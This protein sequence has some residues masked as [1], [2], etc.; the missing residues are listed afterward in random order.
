MIICIRTISLPTAL[1]PTKPTNHRSS[2][3]SIVASSWSSSL[4]YN[5]AQFRCAAVVPSSS[6]LR[7]STPNSA[8]YGL[9]T[10]RSI[11]AKK[12]HFMVVVSSSG[13][14]FAHLDNGKIHLRFS[15]L[16]GGGDL[17]DSGNWCKA[18]M[19]WSWF[20]G[21]AAWE[22]RSLTAVYLLNFTLAVSVCLF[23]DSSPSPTIHPYIH[24]QRVISSTDG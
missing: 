10:A 23:A 15:V 24:P 5:F 11:N 8:H 1:P 6:C 4:Y 9:N 22:N 14:Y 12:N 18:D 3:W 7:K 13:R 2:G 19:N 16:S 21:E 17:A 20:S